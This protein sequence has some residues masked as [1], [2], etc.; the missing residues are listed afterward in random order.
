MNAVDPTRT[1]S[2]KPADGSGWLSIERIRMFFPILVLLVL[3]VVFSIKSPRFLTFNNGMIVAQQAAVLMVVSTGMTFVIIAGSI[4]LS[5]GSIVALSALT[6]AA[7]S[8][9]M[10]Q[11]AILP[12]A[13]VGILCGLFTGVIVAKGKVPS[14]IVTL[15]A[16][17][18]FRGI[19]LYYTRG[20]PVSINNEFFLDIYAS[21]TY[22]IPH[23]AMIAVLIAAA[24]AI[25]LGLAVFG[26]EVRAIGGGEKVARLTGI[27]I[28]R[29]KIT[30]FAVLGLL[31]GIAGLLQAA[32]NFAATSQLGEGL[33]MDV[34]ASVVVGGTPLT[35]GIGSIHGTI[36]GVLIIT[37]LSNGMNMNGVDPYIQNI[38]K[39][40]VLIAAV[41]ITIDRKKIGIIK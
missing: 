32:R 4:D 11:W 14:F 33:E 41:F 39:G 1:E 31:S 2:W 12:A 30:M 19:V 15:G 34:I 22:G 7:A 5:V 26:R 27:N 24:A 18:V 38:V 17:V 21:R 9:R 10:G 35:G 36:L 40:I 28:D 25:V 16:M 29:T 8:D 20:A 3:C 6:T 23:S 13:L 37:I